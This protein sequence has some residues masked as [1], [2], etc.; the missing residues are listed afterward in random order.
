MV[1]SDK[2]GALRRSTAAP[3]FPN[4]ILLQADDSSPSAQSDTGAAASLERTSSFVE[5]FQ[6]VLQLKT[7]NKLAEAGQQLFFTTQIKMG[8]F[9][10]ITRLFRDPAAEAGQPCST[11]RQKEGWF[12]ESG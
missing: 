2:S 1:K 11:C 12:D 3:P 4:R 10:S 5:E 9:V 6:S 8:F 7:S